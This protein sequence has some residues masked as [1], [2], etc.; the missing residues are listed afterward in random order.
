MAT[1]SEDLADLAQIGRD[2]K[3]SPEFQRICL[4]EKLTANFGVKNQ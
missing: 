4:I 3:N 2:L 1:F